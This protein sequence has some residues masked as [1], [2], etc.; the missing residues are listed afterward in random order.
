MRVWGL[1]FRSLCQGTLVFGKPATLGLIGVI[2]LQR[3]LFE[4]CFKLGVWGSGFR[5]FQDLSFYKT[6]KHETLIPRTRN[7]HVVAT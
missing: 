5:L 4:G 3:F 7:P 2:K 6:L 1:G